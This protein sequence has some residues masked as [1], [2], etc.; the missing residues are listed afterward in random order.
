MK[1]LLAGDSIIKGSTGINWISLL[2][3]RRPRWQLKAAGAD[4]E[5]LNKITERLPALLKGNPYDCIVLVAGHNDLL[6]PAL[7]QKG[8]LFRQSYQYL[9]RKGYQPH[10]DPAAFELQMRQ[11]IDL[12]RQYSRARIILCTLSA[13]NESAG[14]LLHQ[15]RNQINE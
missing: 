2:A 14:S 4:G 12:I 13:M 10:P 15:Q 11:C 5:S 1:I 3:Q 6:L 9:L 8:Y 7:S